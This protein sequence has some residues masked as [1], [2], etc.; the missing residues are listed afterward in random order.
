VTKEERPQDWSHEER[1]DMVIACGALDEAAMNQLCCE[2]GLYMH[3]VAQWKQ[4]FISGL[5]ANERAD[6]KNLKGEVRELEKK[7][8]T[9]KTE[10]W[11][12]QRH[13]WYS[14]KS[15]CDLGKRRGQ[16]TM[17]TQRQ[18]I[19]A[20]VNGVMRA[21]AR[22]SAACDIIGISAKTSQRWEQPDNTQDGGLDALH[23]PSTKL[24][25]CER[26]QIITVAN[27]PDYAALS[28]S[29]IVPRL[30]MKGSTLHQNRVFIGSFK[31]AKQLT[32]RLKAKPTRTLKKPET[33]TASGPN[34][35]YSWDITYLPTR[36]RGVFLCLYLVMGIYSR[37]VV[38][39]QVLICT[40]N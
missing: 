12:K 33:L 2:R 7:G 25:A 17:S 23:E 35:N 10:R 30:L 40:D 20:E 16:L 14:K 21:G 11:L 34:Q 39:W 13:Y 36:V 31:A 38:G 8:C 32:H 18:A 5:T 22:Q 27:E 37:K 26:E 6:S 29:K 4:D 1:L 15:Q 28:P 19:I 9:A 3:P 24:T